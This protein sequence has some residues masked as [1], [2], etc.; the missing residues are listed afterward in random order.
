MDSI[1][2]WNHVSSSLLIPAGRI[3]G[4]NPGKA[5]I[6]KIWHIN[7]IGYLYS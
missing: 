6:N 5:G 7:T 2:R 1:R 3:I 4:N